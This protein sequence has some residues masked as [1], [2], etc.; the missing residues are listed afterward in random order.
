MRKFASIIATTG[1][2]L[3]LAACGDSGN[4]D[5]S[6]GGSTTGSGGTGTGTGSTT[7]YEMG[8]GTGG[9]FQSGVI[10]LTSTSLSAGGSTSLAISIVDRTGTL[11]AS[12]TGVP[13][14]I[15][16]PCI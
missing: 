3:V 1:L 12:A 8:N 6:G 4:G 11:Y 9:G 10:G 14:T 5:L 16:S 2:A 15:N 13:V 7:T